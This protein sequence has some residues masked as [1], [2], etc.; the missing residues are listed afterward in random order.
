MTTITE[1]RPKPAPLS[2]LSGLRSGVFVLCAGR[3]LCVLDSAR[4]AWRGLDK[5]WYVLT[6]DEC[7]EWHKWACWTPGRSQTGGLEWE[8]IQ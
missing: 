4:H 5:G 6:P 2:M 1:P 8:G 3:V 7:E